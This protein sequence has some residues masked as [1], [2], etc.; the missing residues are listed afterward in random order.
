[1]DNSPSY[2][3]GIAIVRG[4]PTPVVDLGALIEGVRTSS[5]PR[6][7]SLR[8]ANRIVALAV[9]QVLSVSTRDLDTLSSV[10]PLLGD[11]ANTAIES[12]GRLDADL[13]VVLRA[14]RIIPESVLD[15]LAAETAAP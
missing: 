4:V 8:V 3:L 14:S 12:L 6:F 15:A 9:S 2:V 5:L 13:V 10:P 1:M 11:V 7:V